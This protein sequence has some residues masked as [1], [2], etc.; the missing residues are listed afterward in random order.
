MNSLLNL[1][2]PDYEL[3]VVNDGSP[4]ETLN[5]V[6]EYYKL[7]KIDVVVN[8]EIQ[9]QPIRGIYRNKALPKL[10]V[11]DKH[12]GG[13][14]DSLNAG[15]NLASKRFFCGIDSDSLLEEDALL[16]VVAP[17]MDSEEETVAFGGNIFP[18]N[19]CKVDKGVLEELRLPANILARF[20]TI[21]YLRA[22]MA[23]RVGWAYINCL[24][25]ISGAFGLFS[26]RRVVEI[27]G[28]LT[29]KSKY[30]KDTVGEDM[31]LVVRLGRYMREQKLKHKIAYAFNAN[32]W[33][34]VPENMK[35]LYRQ[36]DRWQRGL[37]DILIFHK[38]LLFN[39]KYGRMGLISIPYF[40][41]FEFIG[42]M[43]EIQGYFMVLMA[44]L[45]GLLNAKIALMLFISSI[46]M[47]V[48]VSI[49]AMIISLKQYPYFK[50]K[51]MFIM[52][53]YAIIENFGFRQVSSF[54]RVTGYINSM[55]KPK[56]WGKMERKGFVKA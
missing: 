40:T 32:C 35:I 18:I 48:V 9:T 49:S 2:Y 50:L 42:P 22:Y 37:I 10:T 53:Y 23:G 38:K 7:K 56:G 46:L 39:R 1:R 24:L 33:T 5:K 19:G 17:L 47:G 54:W 13:K 20:Q 12:N 36:R 4:D 14:A 34:E 3:I 15:I 25:I 29:S 52:I 51:E 43:I 28:Y 30:H 31:E 44:F 6:I 11:I 21:E 27:G 16:K 45:L 26:K 41:I 55:K 8:E